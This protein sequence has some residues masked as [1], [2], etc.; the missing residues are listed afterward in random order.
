MVSDPLDAAEVEESERSAILFP[1]RRFSMFPRGLEDG[2]DDVTEGGGGGE[3][4]E[5]DQLDAMGKGGVDGAAILLRS[6]MFSDPL[7]R[8]RVFSSASSA[9]AKNSEMSS[10][11]FR[12]DAS[13]GLLKYFFV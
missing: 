5:S 13:A 12:F 10:R 9:L 11:A 1:S 6:R 8:S 7:G 4:A 3:L 2:G